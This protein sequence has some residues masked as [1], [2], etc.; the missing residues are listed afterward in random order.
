MELFF[1]SLTCV[2]LIVLCWTD[3]RERRLPNLLTGGG[4]VAALLLRLILGG[5]STFLSGF[6]AAVVGGIFLLIP[7]MLRGAGGGDVKML[8]A[9]G[10]IVGWNAVWALLVNISFAGVI[11]GVAMILCGKL[12]PARLK[13]LGRCCFDWTYDRQAGRDSLPPRDSERVR[14]P[15]GLAIALGMLAV[16]ITPLVVD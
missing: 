4:L 2:W 11:I 12:D 5:F 9:C 14:I 8:A 6:A 15:F 3:C 16:Y 1:A 7:F 10:A 13:H